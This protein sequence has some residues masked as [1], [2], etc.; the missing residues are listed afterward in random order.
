M[1]LEASLW[2]L[3]YLLVL[4]EPLILHLGLEVLADLKV[5]KLLLEHSFHQDLINILEMHAM[6]LALISLELVSREDSQDVLVLDKNHF[7]LVDIEGIFI[8]HQVLCFLEFLCTEF[9]QLCQ[10]LIS[11]WRR[12]LN[13]QANEIKNIDPTR[14]LWIV[15]LPRIQ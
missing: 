6:N 14:C 3:L 2:H 4:F 5:V 10:L 7:L 9:A 12:K 1:R 13:N 8:V 11:K 15:L